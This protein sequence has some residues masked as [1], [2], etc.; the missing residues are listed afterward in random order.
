MKNTVFAILF[1]VPFFL[2]SQGRLEKAKENLSKESTNEESSENRRSSRSLGSGR[3]RDS[4]FADF[5]IELGYYAF[6][7]V[8]VGS[9][10][11][12]NV[13]PYP[14]Y[15]T[16]T[17]EYLKVDLEDSKRSLF[18]IGASQYFNKGIKGLELNANYRVIPILGIDVSH[19]NF[20]ENTLQGKD[21]LNVTSFLL[22]Y[23]R[24]RE[25]NISVWW[26][27]GA[28]HV[29]NEVD[30]MGFAYAI[31]TE[32][33]PAK[34][35]SFHVS[36]KQSFINSTSIDEFKIHLKYHIKKAAI[37]SGYQ[38]VELGSEKVNGIVYGLEYTF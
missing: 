28:T 4:F 8:V 19:L 7:G 38:N 33:F 13:A 11:Y 6:Y 10:E 22:K 25:K 35:I 12:R 5:F 31:G 37:Y 15:Y 20:S 3:D 2:F 27:L 34:P 21:Y 16:S 9:S 29:G 14:Y 23:Y 1:L 36:Y 26:G 17:G 30:S 24:V 18:K 32:I